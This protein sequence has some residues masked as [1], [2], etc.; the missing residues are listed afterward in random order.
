MFCALEDPC[1]EQPSEG[2][3]AYKS[4]VPK[5]APVQVEEL[6]KVR[7]PVEQ[8]AAAYSPEELNNAQPGKYV[9]TASIEPEQE[10]EL[11]YMAVCT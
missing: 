8:L 5:V 7:L 4:R 10:E 9:L 6:Y 2:S 3:N 1:V 11:V